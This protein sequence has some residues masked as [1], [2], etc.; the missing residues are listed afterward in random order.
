MRQASTATAVGSERVATFIAQVYLLMTVGFVITGAVASLVARDMKLLIN[1]ATNPW[2]AWGLFIVQI[3]LVIGL[4]AAAN[5]L[6]GAAATLLFLVY[7][8]V[9]GITLSTISLV[10]SKEDISSVFFIT[11]GMFLLSSL[12]GL[13]LKRDMSAAGGAL[14]M[15]LLGWLF[16]WFFSL[17]VPNSNFNWLL[18]MVGVALFVALTVWDT[19]RLKQIGASAGDRAPGALVAVGALVLYLDFINLFLLLLRARR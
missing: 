7:S 15:L 2:L 18:N 11:A 17:L 16:A 12:V 3:L 13:L 6:S 4:S 14:T 10:Y 5:R 19:Q 9:T 1:V 8:A